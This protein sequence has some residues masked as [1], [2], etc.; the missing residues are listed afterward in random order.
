[1]QMRCARARARCAPRLAQA[2]GPASSQVLEALVLALVHSGLRA[3]HAE[4]SFVSAFGIELANT[5]APLGEA[6]GADGANAAHVRGIDL[7]GAAGFALASFQAAAEA[8]STLSLEVLLGAPPAPGRAS[9][10]PAPEPRPEGR[11]VRAWVVG[12][13]P[14][15]GR[16]IASDA[17]DCTATAAESSSASQATRYSGDLQ[18]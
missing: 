9:H 15:S 1:M 16:S 8:I 10:E 5:H 11:L 6:G 2:L 12:G 18:V 17:S 4:A 13:A 14:G 7:T 3:P